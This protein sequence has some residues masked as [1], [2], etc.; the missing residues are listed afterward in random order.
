MFCFQNQEESI[1]TVSNA[2]TKLFMLENKLQKQVFIHLVSLK[3]LKEKKKNNHLINQKLNVHT[4][5][6]KPTK[7]VIPLL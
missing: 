6:A 3:K 1:T 7:G 4:P 2:L 5:R